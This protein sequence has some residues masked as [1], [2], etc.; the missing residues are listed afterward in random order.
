M[1]QII[2]SEWE[3]LWQRKTPWICLSLIPV[4]LLATLVFYLKNNAHVAAES[5]EYVVFL[6]FPVAALQEQLISAFNIAAILLTILCIT[7]EYTTGQL[8]FVILRAVSPLQIIMAKM[9][10]LFLTM[11]LFMIIYFIGSFLFGYILLPKTSHAAFFYHNQ[12]FSPLRAL[13]YSLQYYGIS[14]FTLMAFGSVIVFFAVISKTATGAAGKGLG[15]LLLFIIYPALL[16]LFVDISSPL[17][18]KLTFLSI[19]YI[20][21]QGIAL[22]LSETKMLRSW[23]F[24]ILSAYITFFSGLS[25]IIFKKQDYYF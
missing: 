16:Q 23:I 22:I 2:F 14:F 18:G 5:P 4:I 15:F 13:F 20:Q 11:L 21:Y 8:R 12:P 19:P 10:V 7:E 9:I 1:H 3:K 24:T 25:F 17:Y 6:N